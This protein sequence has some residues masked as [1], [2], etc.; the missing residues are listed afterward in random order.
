VASTRKITRLRDADPCLLS[1]TFALERIADLTRTSRQVRKTVE[2]I[3]SPSLCD[4]SRNIN[5]LRRHQNQLR[6]P[7]L[8]TDST[9][10]SVRDVRLVNCVG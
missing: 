1:P 6:A 8:N 9:R 7:G 10:A 4:A 2:D 3:F 5:D